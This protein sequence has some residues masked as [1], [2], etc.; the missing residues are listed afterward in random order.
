MCAIIR[1][2]TAS[3][4]SSLVSAM[5][6]AATSASVQCVAIRA[7]LTPYSFDLYRSSRVPMPGSSSTASFDFVTVSAATFIRSYS[8]SFE[9][10]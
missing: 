3:M 4:P 5:C 8:G 1:K 10:P 9:K 2:P 6:C 7:M